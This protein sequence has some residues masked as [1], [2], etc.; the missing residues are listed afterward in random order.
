[1][2]PMRRVAQLHSPLFLLFLLATLSANAAQSR[3]SEPI[4]S[5]RMSGL[6]G[7]V[8]PLARPE[9]DQGALAP[10]AML[11][12][13]TVLFQRTAA[14]QQALDKLLAEQQDPSSANYRKWLTPEQFADRFGMSIADLAKV[15]TWLTGQGFKIDEAARGRGWISFSGSAGQIAQAFQTELHQY[16]VNGEVHFANATEPAVPA[17]LAGVVRGVRGLDNFTPK[18]RLVVRRLKPQ[19]T[20]NVSGNHYLAPDDFARIYN[21][22][23]LYQQGIDGTGQKIAVMGQTDIKTSDIATFR[24]LSGL[25]ANTPQIV[26]VPGSADP[27]IVTDD[28]TEASLDVEWAGAVAKNATIVYVN[29]KNGVFDSLAYAI[30]QNLASV[31]SISYGDC[32]ANF[33]ASDFAF[34]DSAAQQANAQGQTIVGPSGDSGATDCD[35]STT[36]TPTTIAAKGLAVDVPA[37]SPNVTAVGGTT[38]SEANGITYWSTNNNSSNGSALFYIPETAWNDTT[39]ELANGGSLSASG[40]GVSKNY[41]KPS[42]Q[43]GTGVPAD[44]QRDV[45]D[46]AF[47][48]SFDHDGFITCS[49]GSCVN[50]Y[51]QAD[52]TLDIVGGTSAGVPTFAGVVA[53]LN[54]KTGMRQ[55]NLNPQL[56]ALASSAPYVFHDVTSGD[57][58]VPCQPGTADCPSGG[59]IGYSAGPGYDMVT[60]LGTVDAFNLVSNWTAAASADFGVS[61][62][63]GAAVTLARG[64]ST[65]LPLIVQKRNGFSGSVS[66]ACV[67]SGVT[68]STCSVSP[69]SASPDG[70]VSVIVNTTTSASLQGPA[71]PNGHIPW[72]T[73]AFGVAA[74]LGMGGI[75]RRGRRTLLFGVLA[76]A[77]IAGMAAC[78]GGSSSTGSSSGGSTTITAQTGT[79]TVTAT[80]GSL[81][82]TAQVGITVN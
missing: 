36:S 80:S 42:W 76:L 34:I 40:G 54:Q 71:A 60:G 52:Q 73:S 11:Q 3:I 79:V 2:V 48:A 6:H 77:L 26:L 1:M 62:F 49:N 61:F 58:K 44:G 47:N 64:Q 20:S 14:Q 28:L 75:R 53:L 45:P 39:F 63:D 67:I 22:I 10:G 15:Q 24:S 81:T 7:N 78:G 43:A 33:K 30:D 46:I 23:G 38:F 65:T 72:W 66:F 8:H 31:I 9:F 70:T 16:A 17:A 41:A 69:N 25:P 12:R 21:L 13:V 57:N 55:G 68:N 32:E 18:P 4:D 59:S 35:Y 74:F 29:S 37:A 51:R 27:G 5:R 50:G 82:H 19:F 56:Y